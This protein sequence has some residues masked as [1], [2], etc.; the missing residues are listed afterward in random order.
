MLAGLRK[1]N[2]TWAIVLGTLAFWVIGS[3][4]CLEAPGWAMQILTIGVC[5]ALIYAR[6]WGLLFA[7]SLL[8]TSQ[9]LGLLLPSAVKG[10]GLRAYEWPLLLGGASAALIAGTWR[11]ATRQGR[12]FIPLLIWMAGLTI[13]WAA[14]GVAEINPEIILLWRKPFISWHL[15]PLGIAVWQSPKNQRQMLAS[16]MTLLIPLVS[17]QLL[18]ITTGLDPIDELTG[19]RAGFPT[20][21]QKAGLYRP[22][23]FS[24]PIGIAALFLGLWGQ[25]ESSSDRIW[26]WVAGVLGLIS[27]GLDGSRAWLL[28]GIAPLLVM[29]WASALGFLIGLS[30]LPRVQ[31]AA[32]AIWHGRWP[33]SIAQ[34]LTEAEPIFITLGVQ[35]WVGIGPFELGAA[36][37][38]H[39]FGALNMALL[40]GWPA[41][42]L[43]L[44]CGGWWLWR[45][46][47]RLSS[48]LGSSKR[49]RIK[50]RSWLGAGAGLV[51][52]YL[53]TLDLL[54]TSPALIAV[55]VFWLTR[56]SS[57]KDPL[58]PPTVAIT[59]A[60][61]HC[62]T[63]SH[64][65]S[66]R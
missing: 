60:S 48:R 17:L 5:G 31:E 4:L 45:M 65:A 58:E 47:S 62:P 64:T 43:V 7:L 28:L 52:V 19:G 3:A 13:Y 20:L 50:H 49:E 25:R 41:V 66:G 51:L 11:E 30:A 55:A 53:T 59:D 16:L 57:N 23:A 8:M 12:A 44:F 40:F 27:L 63:T 36:L 2:E 56:Y 33:T 35:P 39:D 14:R 6:Q 26:A 37:L 9:P 29:Y 32:L 38:N 34:R 10:P 22:S 61:A 15:V 1:E 42:A 21:F 54:V 18:R 24:G 46:L